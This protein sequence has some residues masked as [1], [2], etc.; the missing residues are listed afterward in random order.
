[1]AAGHQQRRAP[2]RPPARASQ[3]GV[4]RHAP[5]STSRASASIHH[6]PARPKARPAARQSQPS[7]VREQEADRVAADARPH[8]QGGDRQ[9][10]DQPRRRP[11]RGELAVHHPPGGAGVDEL[12]RHPVDG[13][14]QPLPGAVGDVPGGGEQPQVAGTGPTATARRAAGT[15]EPT[16]NA[17][18]TGA[19]RRPVVRGPG[20]GRARRLTG[21]QL[22]RRAARRPPAPGR[23]SP[24]RARRS[25]RRS[26]SSQATPSAPAPTTRGTS[27]PDGQPDEQRDAATRKRRRPTDADGAAR[28]GVGS[29]GRTGARSA[30][31]AAADSAAERPASMAVIGPSTRASSCRTGARRGVRRRPARPPAPS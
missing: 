25:R 2:R 18:A 28:V 16:R 7:G 10:R 30:S 1:M 21:G 22:G 20:Q 26:Q 29:R 24:A 13:V 6:S 8:Q 15:S 23:R 14:G 11:G 4:T 12:P 19:Q 27:H 31:A 3:A 9:Q 5:R 17:S